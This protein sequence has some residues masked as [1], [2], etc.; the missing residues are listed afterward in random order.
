[1]RGRP[2]SRLINRCDAVPWTAACR[3]CPRNFNT[4]DP[5]PRPFG[6]HSLPGTGRRSRLSRFLFHFSSPQVST[7]I[8]RHGDERTKARAMLCLT[9][10]KAIHD[11]FHGARDLLLMS[12]LQV[13]DGPLR[14]VRLGCR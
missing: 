1:M 12:H 7:I 4:Y 5:T 14:R 8:F 6:Q 2:A 9:Y 3:T 10:H 13:R 11:D